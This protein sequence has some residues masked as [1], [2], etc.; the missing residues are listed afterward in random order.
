MKRGS[1]RTLHIVLSCFFS[2]LATCWVDSWRTF[3]CFEHGTL[4]HPISAQ[5]VPALADCWKFSAAVISWNCIKIAYP[6]PA[7]DGVIAASSTGCFEHLWSCIITRETTRIQVIQRHQLL[8]YMARLG[9]MANI[10]KQKCMGQ[11]FLAFLQKIH[12]KNTWLPAASFKIHGFI[13]QK[14]WNQTHPII[15]IYKRYGNK[16]NKP[17][18]FL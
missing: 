6:D 14:T 15:N 4:A 1:K 9:C 17:I 2:S 11:L 7:A 18:G 10:G 3:I 5:K 8:N 13:V 12:W 16:L